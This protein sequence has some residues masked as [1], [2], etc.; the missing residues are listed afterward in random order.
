MSIA[1]YHNI[2]VSEEEIEGVCV[3]VL[4]VQGPHQ[5][6][7]GIGRYLLH[8]VLRIA[9]IAQNTERNVD[10]FVLEDMQ[11]KCFM[12]GYTSGSVYLCQNTTS[13]CNC[14]NGRGKLCATTRTGHRRHASRSWDV[15]SGLRYIA[16]RFTCFKASCTRIIRAWF[17]SDR[18][19]YHSCA[20]M[21]ATGKRRSDLE[22]LARL[23]T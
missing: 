14:E 5:P 13:G 15:R 23:A 16:L 12:V 2:A 3:P 17:S 11:K 7:D 22:A 4:L 20:I 6:P 18:T 10:S 19:C 9:W 8:R 21:N 1:A